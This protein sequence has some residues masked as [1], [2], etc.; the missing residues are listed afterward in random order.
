MQ[1]LAAELGISMDDLAELM[2][3]SA[4]Y[5]AL[6]LNVPE[7]GDESFSLADT[8]GA[9]DGALDAVV[10][11]ESLHPLLDALPPRELRLLLLRFFGNLT[12][13]QIAAEIGVSQMQVS[14]ML[15]ATLGRLRASLLTEDK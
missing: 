14:R 15:T 10:D 1:E 4:A 11:R 9:V 5:S 13:S 7:G 12:Q 3:A 2:E 8:L 6:S